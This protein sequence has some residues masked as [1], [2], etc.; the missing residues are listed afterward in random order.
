MQGAAPAAEVPVDPVRVRCACAGSSTTEAEPVES[1]TESDPVPAIPAAPAPPRTP[2]RGVDSALVERLLAGD[3][4]SFASIVDAWSPS[5]IRVARTF[6]ST[7]AS[8][9]EVVQDTWVAVI[10]GLAAFE[11]RSSVKT[12]VFRIL[13]NVARTRATRESRV[14]PLSSLVDDD[15]RVVSPHEFR[16]ADAEWPGWWWHNEQVTQ[17]PPLPEASVMAGEV[18]RVLAE[19][20]ECLPSRQR[21]VVTLR[22]VEGFGSDEVCQMLGLTAANQRVLLHRARG[23]LRAALDEY[24]N[25]PADSD[26]SPGDSGKEGTA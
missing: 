12:W 9:E 14:T 25:G 8:A 1:R 21:I 5:M 20:L 24:L 13:A 2:S 19:A 4:A 16:P 26:R 11:G 15:D 22:D 6:V 23:K 18:R 3:E 10:R 7:T 17:W